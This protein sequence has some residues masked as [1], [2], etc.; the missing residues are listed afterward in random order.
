MEHDDAGLVGDVLAEHGFQRHL[1]SLY[2]GD[3][4]VTAVSCVLAA[5]DLAH[6]LPW[7][8]RC[9]KDIRM[10]RIE[11]NND[12]GVAV[13]GLSPDSI[14]ISRA[15]LRGVASAPMGVGVQ[16]TREQIAPRVADRRD[17]ECTPRTSS[18]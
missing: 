11:E 2:L 8:A 6:R 12:L 7:F 9:V 1:G 18:L 17:G 16:L 15:T 5:Q 3:E 13:V 10:L 4:S 14:P